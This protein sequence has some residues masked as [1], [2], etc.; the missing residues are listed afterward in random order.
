MR[1]IVSLSLVFALALPAGADTAVPSPDG[2]VP[3]WSPTRGP[4][5]A[6][7]TIV[8]WTDLQCPFCARAQ[9]T[10]EEL[11]RLYPGKIRFVFRHLPLAFHKEA[12]PA[13]EAAMAAH[14]QGRF[15][16][17]AKLLFAAQR[18][19]AGMDYEKL[20]AG[21]GLDARRFRRDLG[22]AQ[23]KAAV[24]RDLEEAQRRHITGTPTFFV[25]GRQ[26]TGAQPV[27]AFRA[28]LDEELAKK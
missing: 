26:V 11:E 1:S 17:M 8:E 24:A 9:G 16:D 18:E 10:L 12:R 6:P 7:I 21:L 5:N 19:L 27:A 3:A 28:I 25:N 23:V 20:A 15:W 13:A 14:A 2:S 4:A 22:S